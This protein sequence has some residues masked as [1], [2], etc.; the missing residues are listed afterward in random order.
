MDAKH[1]YEMLIDGQTAG[2]TAYYDH[3]DQC[4]FHHTKIDEAFAGQGLASPLVQRALTE[5]VGGPARS[6]IN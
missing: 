1:R 6:L 5:L 4:V 3:D 2:F